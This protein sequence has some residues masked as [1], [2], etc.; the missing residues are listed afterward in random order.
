MSPLNKRVKG[1]TGWA[2]VALAVVGLMAVG[3]TRDSGPRT[4]D[5]RV[6]QISER[7]AC[8]ICDGE[9]IAESRS[10]TAE[11]MQERVRDLVRE[12]QLSD[13]EIIADATRQREFRELLVPRSTG[14]DA[15]AWALPAAAFVIAVV[16]LF[17]AFRRWRANAAGIGRAS[18][19]DYELVEAA[20]AAEHD[21]PGE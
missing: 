18:E 4:P 10:A 21:E 12:G 3:I 6:Q 7:I 2:L 16:S 17:F 9:N 15:L 20:L 11:N 8:P 19:Q 13:E 14:L 5:E 1:W